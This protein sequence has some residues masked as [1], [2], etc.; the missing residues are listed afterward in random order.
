[1]QTRLESNWIRYKGNLALKIY[2]FAKLHKIKLNQYT[3]F[4]LL[5]RILKTS[6]VKN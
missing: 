1:M 4:K 5:T 6:N 2:L 3:V